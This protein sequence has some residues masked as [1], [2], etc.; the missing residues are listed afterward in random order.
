MS[1]SGR[2]TGVAR[3]EC[4]EVISKVERTAVRRS[5]HRMVRSLPVGSILLDLSENLVDGGCLN[6]KMV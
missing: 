4:V 3:S 6:D 2:G 5:L 1:D